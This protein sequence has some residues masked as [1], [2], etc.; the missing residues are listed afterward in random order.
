[1]GTTILVG[2]VWLEI[3]THAKAMRSIRG[4]FATRH[5]KKLVV[6]AA[7]CIATDVLVCLVLSVVGTSDI[8]NLTKALVTFYTLVMIG[9]GVFFVRNTAA[10]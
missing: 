7:C 4:S 8:A 10:F 1:M 9:A 6:I 2:I 5:R 3:A